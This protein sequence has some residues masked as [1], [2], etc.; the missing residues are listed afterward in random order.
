MAR[1]T[2][3]NTGFTIINGSGT[4][5][6][7]NRIDVWAEYK[8]GT[9][10]LSGNYTP[11]TVY[12]Y[13]ALRSGYQSS[14][15]LDR[16]LDSALKVDGK[17]GSGVSNGAYSFE[18]VSNINALGSFRGN[19]AHNSDGTKTVSIQGSFTTASSYISGGSV[20][21]SVVLPVIPRAS[22]LGATDAEI[23]KTSVIAVSVKSTGYTHSI[24]YSFGNLSGYITADGKTSSTQV[25]L[26]ATSIPFAVPDSFYAQIPDSKTGVCKLSCKTY[27]GNTQIGAEQTAQFTVTAPEG[28]CKPLVSGSVEDVNPVTLALTGDNS[29]LIKGFS[30]ARCT[31]AAQPQKSA[32]IAEKRL[33]GTLT[34]ADTLELSFVQQIPVFYAKDSRGYETRFTP[35]ATLLAYRALTNN[36]SVSRDDPTSGNATVYLRGSYYAGS[37]GAAD[38][39]ISVSYSLNGGQQ[40]QLQP[41]LQFENGM[42]SGSFPLSGLDYTCEHS[43][44]LT[45]SDRL[46]S[47]TKVL[48]VHKG[49]PVFDW[50]ETD[51]VFHVPVQIPQL[52]CPQL[53]AILQRLDALETK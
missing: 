45:V 16:G 46:C 9:Q 33:G 11:I 17:A 35:Q 4:G 8:L 34:A 31:M 27:S 40:V 10:S 37:F 43:L 36:A 23:G 25:K 47:V 7:G 32:S 48:S 41:Q 15:A 21:A 12:F 29:V 13:A 19:I 49:V 28:T 50:G 30:T 14:T 6:N 52:S 3:V 1:T 22:T 44:Q 39:A 51:F 42:Y 26:S 5:I 20:S 53:D 2:P 18:A 38:N 24:R